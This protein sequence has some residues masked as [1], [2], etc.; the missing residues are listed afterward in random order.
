MDYYQGSEENLA[1]QLTRYE[2]NICETS[3]IC[4]NIYFSKTRKAWV[5]SSIQT[6]FES[7]VLDLLFERVNNFIEDNRQMTHKI[8][9]QFKYKYQKEEGKK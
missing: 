3:G 5:A 8:N 9:Y 4:F 7:V 2:Q 1:E 6:K